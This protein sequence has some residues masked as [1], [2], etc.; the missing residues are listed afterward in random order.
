MEAAWL[1]LL[2]LGRR[3]E[4]DRIVQ[5]LRDHPEGV[6][7]PFF[8]LREYIRSQ[9]EVEL[10]SDVPE[11]ER[12]TLEMFRKWREMEMPEAATYLGTGT[13]AAARERGDFSR[14]LPAW[15][16]AAA[17]SHVASATSA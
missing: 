13:F 12:V 8:E 3:D 2:R 11:L 16:A 4:V 1:I 17:T 10:R 15:A 9:M 6:A 5:E 14:A 7:N